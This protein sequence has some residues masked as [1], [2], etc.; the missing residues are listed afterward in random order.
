M[1]ICDTSKAFGI[2]T[3]LYNRHHNLNFVT[4]SSSPKETLVLYFLYKK[5]KK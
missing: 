3:E 2:F 4:F 5:E 1:L